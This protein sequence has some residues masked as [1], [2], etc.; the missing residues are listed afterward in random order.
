MKCRQAPLIVT[1]FVL[2]GCCVLATAAPR[3]F[4]PFHE[5]KAEYD[6]RAQWLRDAKVGVF[7]HWN[8][9]SLIGKEI[10]WCR[11]AC[12]K[13]KYDQLY[14]QFK[15]EK[16]NADEW[17]KLFHE[18]GIRYAVIVPK[19][20]DGFCMFDTKEPTCADYNVMKTP[21]GKDYVKEMAQACGKSDVRFCLY[22]SV[23]DWWNPTYKSQAGADLSAYK[24]VFKN[25]MQQ[26]LTEYGP[27]GY[28]WF[29]G[30][31]DPSWTHE[32]GRELYAFMRKVQ[33]S[34][35][36]G[37]RIEPRR[38]SMEAVSTFY[39]AADAV[40]DFQAREMWVGPFYTNKA[41]DSC[42]NVN[43]QGWAWVPP[44]NPRPLAE[45]A[46]WIMQC[47]G[48][49]GGALLGVGPRPDGTIDPG[50]AARLLELG[51]WLKTNGEA[52]YGTR[53]GPYLPGDWG[54]STRKGDKVF[55]FVQKWKGDALT[56]PA[57]PAEVKSARVLTGG[58]V[59]LDGWTLRV[60]AEFHRPIAT[61]VEL[62]LDQDAMKLPVIV[63][64]EPKNLARGKPVKV[65]SVWPGRKEL[66][67]SHITDGKPDT[68]W[69]AKERT[70]EAWVTVDLQ[71]ECEVSEAI[72]SDAPYG[73]TQEFDLE[74][75]VAGESKK[76]AAGKTI[77]NELRLTFAPVK[78][79]LFRLNIR[80]ASDT[81]TLAEFQLFGK[82]EKGL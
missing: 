81:P 11:N 32:N 56:L 50:H 34:T 40:G 82:Q 63:V 65:S 47:I 43:I 26:L 54:V 22:Y 20:H 9:S 53:G 29:D 64:P 24:K 67:K 66:D 19:H 7:I 6:V 71:S 3:E 76:L 49:D 58:T 59:A 42:L 18:S 69:A 25:H 1:L 16:F 4:D 78:A 5:T 79:R 57:L 60:P 14:K 28:V 36:L 73:R 45:L 17:V 80:K 46:K 21:F 12:G 61:I 48:R 41:W 39:P 62:T 2:T 8:P 55:L 10:S 72:L 33:P 38:G 15:G 30:C 31:W 74:A 37:N 52:I 27:V 44:V 70:R 77:G 35:L 23:C 51:D 75:Q 13:E 68:L